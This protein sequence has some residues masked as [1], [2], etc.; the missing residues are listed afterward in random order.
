MALEK[1][2]RFEGVAALELAKDAG[3]ARAEFLR[4]DLIEDGA[5]LGVARD[6]REAEERFEVDLIAAALLVEGQERGCF[7]REDGIARHEGVLQRDFSRF[8]T[9]IEDLVKNGAH[10]VIESVGGQMLAFLRVEIHGKS[11]CV[12]Q[13]GEARELS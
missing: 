12:Q 10:K 4:V 2:E 11:L 9:M 6:V 5:H 8:G 7:E 13:F 3:E 1:D